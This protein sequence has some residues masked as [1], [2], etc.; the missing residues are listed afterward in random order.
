[1][2]KEIFVYGD[3]RIEI[4]DRSKVLWNLE[5]SKWEELMFEL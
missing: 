3:E 4:K 5:I 1:M 2:E